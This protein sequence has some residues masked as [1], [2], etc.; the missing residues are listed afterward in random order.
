MAK[1][2]G[3]SLSLGGKAGTKKRGMEA[4]HRGKRLSTDNNQKNGREC[5]LY[6][7]SKYFVKRTRKKIYCRF[8]CRR[9]TGQN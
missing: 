7:M 1:K 5:N 3:A 6:K 4:R 2:Q 8:R 9:G